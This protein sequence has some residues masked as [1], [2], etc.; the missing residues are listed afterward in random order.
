MIEITDKIA[1]DGA[2]IA[3]TYIRASG[4]AGRM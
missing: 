3:V 1:L 2:E 4:P